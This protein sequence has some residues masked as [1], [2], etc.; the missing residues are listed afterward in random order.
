MYVYNV[1]LVV[2]IASWVGGRS[3]VLY[4]IAMEKKISLC[5]K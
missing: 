1:I 4:H 5:G 2:M 3:K